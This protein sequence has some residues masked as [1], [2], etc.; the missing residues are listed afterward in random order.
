MYIERVQV[1]EGFLNGLDIKLTSGLNAIIGARGTGKTS[2]I[3]LIRFCLNVPA[4]TQDV[5]KKSREHAL[6]ILGSGQVTVT[7]NINGQLVQ[8]TRTNSDESPR[9]NGFYLHPLIF[10]QK[11]IETIG[12]E[13]SGRLKL[14]D[15]FASNA[16]EDNTEEKKTIT[17]IA[18]LT[19]EINK[20]N[21]EIDEIDSIARELPKIN[22]QLNNTIALELTLANT[23][24][25]L[26][27]KTAKLNDISTELSSISV[28]D[29]NNKR[30]RLEI[31]KWYVL[32]N[33]SY[34]FSFSELESNNVFKEFN[35]IINK[36]KRQLYDI[37]IEIYAVHEKM[38]AQ[39]IEL[40]AKKLEIEAKSRTLRQEVEHF[41]AGSGEILRKGQELREKKAR[42]ESYKSLLELKKSEVINL[43]QKRSILF[44]KLDLIRSTKFNERFSIS[45]LLNNKLNPNINVKI[46]RNAQHNNFTSYLLDSLKGS[47]MKYNEIAPAIAS[48]LSPRALLEAVDNFDSELVSV[49]ANISSERATRLLSHLK[50]CDLSYLGAV[51]IEDDATLQLLDGNDYKS[52]NLLST[53]QRC[54]VI[55]PIV[56]AHNEKILIVD[57]PEDHIDNAFITSTLIKSLLGRSNNGQIIFSTHNPNIPVLGNADNVIHL[58]SDG[59]NGFVLT[60]GDLEKNAVVDAITTVMEGGAKA[61]AL[62]SDFYSIS[63]NK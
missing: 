34:E 12:L 24:A 13:A 11:E 30:A 22:E 40:S 31:E 10:S 33:S 6:S 35:D 14:I 21:K 63:K 61:F 4:N 44:D 19:T 50:T 29:D 60:Q 8:V 1:E 26:N 45:K 37:L 51:N 17:E 16:S 57:Q 5:S 58:G 43:Q 53:G 49:A 25:S 15:S 47:G 62:R 9:S 41:Q 52:I 42:Y 38:N 39:A 36:S 32:I 56:L 46:L 48:T 27:E 23:S 2:L 28:L 18:S 59:R 20:K 54:S 3:E 55:L 7:L